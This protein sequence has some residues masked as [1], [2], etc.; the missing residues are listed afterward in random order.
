[1]AAEM[2]AQQ[3]LADGAVRRMLHRQ[4]S[5]A[6]EKW[7]SAAAEMA[8]QERKLRQAVMRLVSEKLMAYAMGGALRRML[9]R[10]LSMAFE[11]WQSAAAEMKEEARKL[12]Q[13]MMRLVAGKLA[14]GFGTW[15]AMAASQKQMA[16]AMGGAL[17]RM[18]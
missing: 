11:K 13:A 15:R 2:R 6:F 9:N 14:A 3:R 7:Q 12:R 10:Q 18:L 1:M 8:E 17:R 5:M 4:F 16:Y